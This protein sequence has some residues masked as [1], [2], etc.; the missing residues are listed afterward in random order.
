[1]AIPLEF[2]DRRDR[3]FGREGDLIA[4][5]E[6]V[7]HKGLTA[8]AARPFMGKSWLLAEL[9]RRLGADEEAPALVGIA[10]SSGEVPDL[11]LRAVVDLYVRWLSDSSL[12]QQARMTW[13]QQKS[14]LLTGVAGAV[15]RI[16][17]EVGVPPSSPSPWRSRKRSRD[18]WLPTGR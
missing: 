16:F 2:P 5:R 1:M 11:L 8:V 13:E 4:L 18:W 12:L 14:N 15:S 7:R 17:K 3:L 9:A 10:E 6:R